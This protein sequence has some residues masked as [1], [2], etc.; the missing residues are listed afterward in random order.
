MLYGNNGLYMFL[1][2]GVIGWNFAYDYNVI[3]S[4][5]KQD[6]Y[7]LMQFTGLH[8]K[9]G[10]EIYHHDIFRSN[11]G[12]LF[13]VVWSNKKHGWAVHYIGNAEFNPYK[14]MN[15]AINN[16]EVVGNIYEPGFVPI[17]RVN[18]L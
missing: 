14:S 5:T 1:G 2:C 11:K 16:G 4:Y 13:E 3:G 15:W 10:K 18:Q 6:R 12:R 8:D 17:K 7:I 9:N